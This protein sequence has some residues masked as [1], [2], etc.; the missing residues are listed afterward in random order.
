MDTTQ[1]SYRFRIEP[2]A[3]IATLEAALQVVRRLDIEL[4]GLR[5]TATPG[6]MEVRMHLA[7]Q[8]EDIL[9][10]CRMRLHNLMGVL[11]IREFRQ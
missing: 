4:R 11:P 1:K 2:D 8:E 5:T 9:T 10:L 7:A 3:P 6:G